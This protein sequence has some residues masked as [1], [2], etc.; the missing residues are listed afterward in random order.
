M[1]KPRCHVS[2][3]YFCNGMIED[4]T[5]MRAFVAFEKIFHETQYAGE[6]DNLLCVLMNLNYKYSI[7]V[8]QLKEYG[9]P[10]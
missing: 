2:K 6:S 10:Y 1:R 5:Y 4:L 3:K 8:A 9:I 7:F